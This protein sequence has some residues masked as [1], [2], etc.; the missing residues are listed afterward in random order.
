MAIDVADDGGEFGEL[1]SLT[2]KP[3]LARH[4]GEFVALA[5]GSWA[6]YELTLTFAS[7]QQY[8]RII[9]AVLLFYVA[10]SVLTV[11]VRNRS[12]SYTI[13]AQRITEKTG[14]FSRNTRSIELMRIQN[15][16]VKESFIQRLF[17]VGNVTVITQDMTNPYIAMQSIPH[18]QAL[19]LWL[20]S[21]VQAARI[22][23]GFRE[24]AI[25]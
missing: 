14:I 18:T 20:L 19:R 17:D 21:H 9:S 2:V 6:V 16:I 10:V 23:Q 3:S 12:T 15:I 25:G 8:V 22:A 24:I 5:V 1:E 7:N 13:D 4:A 11:F